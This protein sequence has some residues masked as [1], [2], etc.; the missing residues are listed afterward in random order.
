VEK[1]RFSDEEL[2]HEHPRLNA[3]LIC[4]S[5]I[6]EQGTGKVS[7]IGI[8]ANVSAF[9]FPSRHP[10]LSV[11]ANL[12]DAAGKYRFKLTLHRRDDGAKLGE[13]G[14]DAEVVDRMQPAELVFELRDL[15]FEKPGR[16]DF[17]LLANGREVGSKVF[18][19][20]KLE[21]Q[22]GEQQ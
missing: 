6:R 18:N 12:A 8:F 1:G 2:S 22:A 4:D 20:V 15:W 16:Y 19:V 21:T 17:A 10:T 9:S 3:M 5:T 13:G 14:M 7:L 11:Y